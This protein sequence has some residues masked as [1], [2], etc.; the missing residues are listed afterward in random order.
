MGPEHHVRINRISIAPDGRLWVEAFGSAGN[1]WDVFDPEGRLLGSVPLVEWKEHSVPAF[2]TDHM[3][4]IHQDSLELD[5]V[6]VWRI[7]RE[8]VAN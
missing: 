7:E 2:G 4:T 8:A 6:D 5:H 1:R 3:L